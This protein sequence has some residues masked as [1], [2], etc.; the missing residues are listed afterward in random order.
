MESERLEEIREFA[1]SWEVSKI[2]VVRGRTGA[3]MA[4]I[5]NE[6]VDALEKYS[7]SSEEEIGDR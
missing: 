1:N 4:D 3:Y 7:A 6:L 5:L 2:Y